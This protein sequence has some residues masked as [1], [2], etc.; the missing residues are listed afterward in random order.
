MVEQITPQPEPYQTH[1]FSDALPARVERGGVTHPVP[2]ILHFEPS[3]DA[4]S[5][6]SDVISS[7]KILS[8]PAKRLE[9]R[10]ACHAGLRVE[11]G[12]CGVEGVECR[13]QGVGCRVEGVGC[14][15]EG[16]GYRVGG[17]GFRV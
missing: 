5:L 3:L 1:F 11:G 14:R 9:S 15:V 12:G 10:V 6:R 8:H 13:V 4:L 16:V 2:Y 7:I 17:A